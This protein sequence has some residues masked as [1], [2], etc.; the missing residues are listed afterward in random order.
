MRKNILEKVVEE[1][2]EEIVRK[3]VEEVPT[4][5]GFQER[6]NGKIKGFIEEK[7]GS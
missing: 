6:E 7:F 2:R 5:K 4:L 1:L 3:V